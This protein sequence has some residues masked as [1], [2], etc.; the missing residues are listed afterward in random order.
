[1]VE[2]VTV[3]LNPWKWSRKDDST[4]TARFISPPKNHE[5]PRRTV[6]S[7]RGFFRDDR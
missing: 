6:A 2:L 4:G 5:D 3:Q 7:L 1:M